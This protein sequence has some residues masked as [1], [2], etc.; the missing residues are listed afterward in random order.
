MP[1]LTPS[2]E[3]GLGL[4]ASLDFC[5]RCCF[6]YVGVGDASTP[7]ESLEESVA[8]ILAATHAAAP[9]FA[10]HGVRR[11]SACV[12]ILCGAVAASI[13]P[14]SLAT[15]S[16][17][18]KSPGGG[19]NGA[20]RDAA[21]CA[22][23][24]ADCAQE[25][26]PDILD[27]SFFALARG[28]FDL[29]DGLALSVSLTA[30]LV[31]VDNSARVAFTNLFRDAVGK[32]PSRAVDSSDAPLRLPT[33]AYDLRDA[34]RALLTA[35]L[36]RVVLRAL[37]PSTAVLSVAQ[38]AAVCADPVA[39]ESD[40]AVTSGGVPL[41]Q[42]LPSPFADAPALTALITKADEPGSAL[43]T[44]PRALL[45]SVSRAVMSDFSRVPPRVHAP[46]AVRARTS[47]GEVVSVHS[48]DTV[49]ALGTSVA[50]DGG[51]AQQ[52]NATGGALLG[53]HA[54]DS[55]S[56]TDAPL[57]R[58]SILSES[59]LTLTAT[60]DVPLG[61]SVAGPARATLTLARAPLF[62]RGRY[63]KLMRGL[64]Q[65][66]WFVNG[67]RKELGGQVGPRELTQASPTK[68]A[69]ADKGS[70]EGDGGVSGQTD[71]RAPVRPSVSSSSVEELLGA[72][73]AAAVAAVSQVD[74]GGRM[75]GI[76][77]SPRGGADDGGESLSLL[78]ISPPPA[79]PSRAVLAHEPA[80]TFHAAGRED[81]DVRM[82]GSGRPFVI[83]IT[84]ARGVIMP[85]CALFS[86]A[87]TLGGGA[88]TSA[89]LRVHVFA[90]TTRAE[91]A[92]L[93]AG[94]SAK[95]KAY[96]A[97]VWTSAPLG[98]VGARSAVAQLA[99]DAMLRDALGRTGARGLAIAQR[100]P[101]RVL[102]RRSLLT[103]AKRVLALNGLA[104]T[105]HF[106]LLHLLTSAGTYVKEFVHGDCGR[107]RPHLAELLDPT[108]A[109]DSDILSLDVVDHAEGTAGGDDDVADDDDGGD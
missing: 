94:A 99:L 85:L 80:Y 19:G 87:D 41:P 7:I 95:R 66:P 8:A 25:P 51:D 18:I 71:G 79:T 57:Q 4:C 68:R 3:F 49:V 69:R 22:V 103:R 5:A 30:A 1:P 88:A 16:T 81:V 72:P 36:S 45:A 42:S 105:P 34:T 58:L 12:G 73:I 83:E 29:R 38:A 90:P 89:P 21:G 37:A 33:R 61:G 76:A 98:G 63:C 43:A 106:F 70:A 82:L 32:L 96:V 31:A 35:G 15:G 109:A 97:L 20:G 52:L 91:F 47:R 92:Q 50:A 28:G 107:T 65:T 100:T 62:F 10:A 102:H 108:G 67:E 53:S 56:T 59:S 54:S 9:E 78:A 84:A 46:E 93:Q 23:D 6:R 101:I 27:A 24:D 2:Q 74:G 17:S 14:A 104:I 13:P 75:I 60:L 39:A 48:S 86:L 11:C 44:D 26:P 40:N 55:A 77:A 64:S